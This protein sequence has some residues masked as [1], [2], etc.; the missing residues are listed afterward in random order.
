MPTSGWGNTSG[1][2]GAGIPTDMQETSES[3]SDLASDSELTDTTLLRRN[4]SWSKNVKLPPFL[5]KEP[6]EIWF[7]R[8]SDVADRHNWS[9]D[10]RLDELLPKLQGQAGEFVYGQLKQKVRNNYKA[11][12][13]ELKNRFC[14]IETKKTYQARFSNFDQ[15]A[16]VSV[17]DYAAELKRLY[18]RAYGERDDKTQREDQIG[19][20][21]V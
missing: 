15:K 20:A 6:W 9:D 21:H 19:R 12:V 18:D 8:F 13:K 16:N 1:N 14:K 11:L 5:G 2:M 10:Q 3:S 17:E 4:K 7:N